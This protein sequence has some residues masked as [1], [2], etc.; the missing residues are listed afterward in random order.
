LLSSL[1]PARN[2]FRTMTGLK[3]AFALPLKADR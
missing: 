2:L 1:C 3:R